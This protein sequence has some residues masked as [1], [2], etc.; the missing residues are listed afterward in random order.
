MP[1]H[2][3]PLLCVFQHMGLKER[4]R[5]ALVCKARLCGECRRMV[6][7]Y[8]CISFNMQCTQRAPE[9]AICVMSRSGT[10]SYS[11]RLCGLSWI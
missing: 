2:S 8:E 3:L 9:F 5:T 4:S 10:G 1:D 11:I 6:R 7:I